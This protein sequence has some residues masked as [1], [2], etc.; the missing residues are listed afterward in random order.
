MPINLSN[1]FS[2]RDLLGSTHRLRTGWASY[3][4]A[5]S[6]SP[7][8]TLVDKK[9]R[10]LLVEE[11]IDQR[12]I[13]PGPLVLTGEKTHVKRHM[14]QAILLTSYKKCALAR[15][16]KNMFQV[17]ALLLKKYPFLL[18]GTAPDEKQERPFS[19]LTTPFGKEERRNPPFQVA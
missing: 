18:L 4:D 17:P 1:G 13:L 3:C 19:E 6:S 15:L 5:F 7:L 14:E 9:E 16:Q 11:L 12:C 8:R 2:S 10:I